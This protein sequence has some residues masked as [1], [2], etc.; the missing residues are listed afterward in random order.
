MSRAFYRSPNGDM[1]PRLD[2][3]SLGGGKV[4]RTSSRGEGGAGGERGGGG[5]GEG[6]GGGGRDGGG[7]DG[8]GGGGGGGGGDGGGEGN[9]HLPLDRWMALVR[10]NYLVE[11]TTGTT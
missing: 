1:E 10:R 3:V 9:L 2:D 11:I 5:G 4:G 6:G 7:G 8:G